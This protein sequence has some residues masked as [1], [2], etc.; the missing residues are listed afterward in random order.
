M[1]KQAKT[2]IVIQKNLELLEKN[3]DKNKRPPFPFI[4]NLSLA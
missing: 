4:L 2:Q 1:D 3:R